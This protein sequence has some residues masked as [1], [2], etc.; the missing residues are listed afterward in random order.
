MGGTNNVQARARDSRAATIAQI[1]RAHIRQQL[2]PEEQAEFDEHY[3][4]EE[5]LI[6]EEY[7]E[8]AEQNQLESEVAEDQQ[9][10]EQMDY[11][12]Q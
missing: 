9:N 7:E 3:G 5:D 6:Y 1:R 8:D 4:E 2:T 11:Y 10:Q 12:M